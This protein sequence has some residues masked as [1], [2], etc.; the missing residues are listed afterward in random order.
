MHVFAKVRWFGF[1][2]VNNQL[3]VSIRDK[4]LV[5]DCASTSLEHEVL[6]QK[7]AVSGQLD[8]LIEN[9]VT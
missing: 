5:M 9:H 2:A 1:I 3:Q 4:W 8:V 7:Q 6:R